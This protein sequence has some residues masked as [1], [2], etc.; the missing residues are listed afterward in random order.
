[1]VKCI[2]VN[3]DDGRGPTSPQQSKRLA[4]WEATVYYYSSSVPLA[5]STRF[6]HIP[7]IGG[8]NSESP[9]SLSRTGLANGLEEENGEN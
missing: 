9:S 8:T 5:R 6:P 1:M 2:K 4:R 7:L 3:T